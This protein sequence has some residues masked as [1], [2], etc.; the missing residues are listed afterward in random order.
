MIRILGIAGCL[1]AGAF[2]LYAATVLEARLKMP[3]EYSVPDGKER[4]MINAAAFLEVEG[5][6]V[7]YSVWVPQGCAASMDLQL[8]STLA[9]E[10]VIIGMV[11]SEIVSLP[12]LAPL[13]SNP[14][15]SNPADGFVSFDPGYD[16]VTI[17]IPGFITYEV[18]EATLSDSDLAALLLSGGENLL[19]LPGQLPQDE[20]VVKG[21]WAGTVVV[22]PEASSFTLSL[23]F[24]LAFFRRRR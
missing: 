4:W 13:P 8:I 3:F 11:F 20:L 17:G 12:A 22:I 23:F 7:K 14:W 5:D 2:P 6:A 15:L 21:P 18:Y 1:F 16:V 9:E 19:S 10:S 24:G